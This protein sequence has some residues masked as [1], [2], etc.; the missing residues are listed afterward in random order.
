MAF[1]A[2]PRVGKSQ[3]IASGAW[4]GTLIFKPPIVRVLLLVEYPSIE[5][6]VGTD[7]K[8]LREW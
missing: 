1:G 4:P 3:K 8:R 5:S 2:A 7:M 6:A